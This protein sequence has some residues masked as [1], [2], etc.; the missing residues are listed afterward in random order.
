[1]GVTH[2]SLIGFSGLSSLW[3]IKWKMKVLH[4]LD[5]KMYFCVDKVEFNFEPYKPAC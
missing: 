2:C 5:L 1:M 4:E 3:T